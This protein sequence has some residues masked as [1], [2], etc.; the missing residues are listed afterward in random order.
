MCISCMQKSKICDVVLEGITH[1][2]QATLESLC[3]DGMC[4]LSVHDMWDL[5][6]SVAWHQ[7]H[8]EYANES[9]V[10]PFP[11]PYDFHTQSPCTDQFR[12]ICDNHSSY[13]QDVCIYMLDQMP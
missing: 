2:T 11:P 8:Y 13:P 9:F 5:F 4:C 1:E 10:C 3:H 7:W 6:E 12:D